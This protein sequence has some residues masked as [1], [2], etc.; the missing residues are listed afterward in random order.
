ML[1]DPSLL[2][3]AIAQKKEAKA[4]KNNPVFTL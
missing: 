1:N 4:T 2:F 3:L